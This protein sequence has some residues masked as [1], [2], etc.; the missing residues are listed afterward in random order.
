MRLLE[1]K[2]AGL[3]L[4]IGRVRFFYFPP[5]LVNLDSFLTGGRTVDPSGQKRRKV[6]EQC[7]F[8]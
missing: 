6:T 3:N 2:N 5:L 1:Y 4:T 7:V 8:Y